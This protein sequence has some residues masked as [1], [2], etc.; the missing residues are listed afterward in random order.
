MIGQRSRR[1]PVSHTSQLHTSFS[2]S[3]ARAGRPRARGGAPRPLGALV[4]AP[5]PLP[6][7]WTPPSLAGAS[8]DRVGLAPGRPLLGRPLPGAPLPGTP[9]T[10]RDAVLRGTMDDLRVVWLRDRVYKAFGLTD[11]QLFEELLCRD[12]GQGEDLIL[13]FLNQTSDEEGAATLF[14]YR[15]VVS[16]EVEVEVETGEPAAA[17]RPAPPRAAGRRPRPRAPASVS[18][19]PRAPASVSGRPPGRVGLAPAWA[20]RRRH[21]CPRPAQPA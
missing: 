4:G 6:S 9:P 1:S 12:E 19:R 18:G 15:T 8:G 3:P 5:R 13:H 11:P 21:P 2:A 10:R 14:F 16:E 17:R 20:R 7:G